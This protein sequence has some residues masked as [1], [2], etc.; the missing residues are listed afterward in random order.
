MPTA[1][2]VL[3]WATSVA[4]EWR[5]LAVFW[6]IALGAFLLAAIRAQLSERL[7]ARLLVLPIVSV[8][9]VA[10]VSGNPFNA[11]A[12]AILAVA[13]LP[14]TRYLPA[15][16]VTVTSPRWLLVG[17][18]LIA[19]G[20]L[21]PHFVITNAWTTYAYAAPFGLL[22]CPTLLVVI[23]VTF[24]LGGF[25]VRS[26]AWNAVVAAA[27]AIYGAIG[28]FSL[29]VALDAWLLGG[30]ILLATQVLVERIAGRVRATEEEC[31]RPLPGDR[32]I[33][34]ATG[35]MTNAIT[36]RGGASAVWPKRGRELTR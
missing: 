21:Y 13:L 27:G 10:G 16:R 32:F 3:S 6:H 15:T 24:A 19:V 12:F 31:A 2:A 18:P 8:A 17:V 14:L 1:E 22:P 9:I 28:V 33:S 35:A 29:G 34:D 36:M 4:N 20:W 11:V 30:A 25:G 7:A 26:A 5:G 23:G